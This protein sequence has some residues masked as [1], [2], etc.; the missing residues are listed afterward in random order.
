MFINIYWYNVSVCDIESCFTLHFFFPYTF[1]ISY[2]L[3]LATINSYA[4]LN[5]N[6]QNKT[7][8]V[9][10]VILSWRSITWKQGHSTDNRWRIRQRIDWNW[11]RIFWKIHAILI[12][13]DSV[14]YVQHLY[15][16][17]TGLKSHHTTLN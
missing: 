8:I 5:H 12:L 9:L 4:V 17:L 14:K 15:V 13:D 2:M 6:V 1:L 10:I 11:Y 3:H 16:W 7:I